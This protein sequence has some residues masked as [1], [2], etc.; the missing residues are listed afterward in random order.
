MMRRT[1]LIYGTYSAEDAPEVEALLREF[2]AEAIKKKWRFIT[3]GATPPD[4]WP[5]PQEV[6]PVDRIVIDTIQDNCRDPRKFRKQLR[7]YVNDDDRGAPHAVGQEILTIPPRR[8]EMYTAF[9]DQADSI[10]FVG[11]ADGVLRLGLVAHFTHTPFVAIAAFGGAA[12]E[13]AQSFYP[14]GDE[15]HYGNIR[16]DDTFRLAS[17]D[18]TGSELMKVTARATRPALLFAT[19]ETLRRRMTVK[20]FVRTLND[21]IERMLGTVGRV[22]TIVSALSLV[23]FK[24][25]QTLA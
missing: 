12:L 18:L 16:Q 8:F 15:R 25:M 11:G 2:V 5:G 23:A 24:I 13:I 17:R 6:I 22:L 4:M 10:V 1:I 9:L 3:R 14:R 19:W 7:S 21:T 20:A